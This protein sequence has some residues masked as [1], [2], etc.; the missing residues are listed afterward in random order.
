MSKVIKS[1]VD[2]FPGTVTLYDPLSFPQ[3]IAIEKATVASREF[4]TYDYF[5]KDCEHT[6]PEDEMLE[7][8][9]KCGGA[10]MQRVN[11]EESGTTNE[12]HGALVP[13]I[14]ECVKEWGLEGIGNPPVPFPATP[15]V[16]ANKLVA[17]VYGEIIALFL[18]TQE[19]PEE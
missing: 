5:C 15:S 14:M 12:Y 6:I 18:E 1:P 16:P 7:P 10:I 11:W 2:K 4:R 13:A 3:V 8:C 9:P 19:I 17:W